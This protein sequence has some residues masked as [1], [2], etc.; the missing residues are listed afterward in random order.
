M[1]AINEHNKAPEIE[2]SYRNTQAIEE[3]V[4]LKDILG[5][6]EFIRSIWNDGNIDLQEEFKV[7]LLNHAGHLLGVYNVHKGTMTGIPIDLR[8]IFGT[9]LKAAA[10]KIILAHNHP[11]GQCRPSQNDIKLTNRAIEIG[12]LLDIEIQDHLIVTRE[13]VFSFAEVGLL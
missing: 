2:I 3:R 12:K 13:Q 1:E 11:S 7:L 4:T 6:K 9:A 5:A 8:L 10:M